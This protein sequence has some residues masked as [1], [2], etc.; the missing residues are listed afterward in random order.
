MFSQTAPAVLWESPPASVTA[1]QFWTVTLL[2]D[3]P[4]PEEVE[5][6]LPPLP[7]GLSLDRVRSEPRLLQIPPPGSGGSARRWTSLQYRFLARNPGRIDLGP[8]EV[9][10]GGTFIPGPALSLTVRNP[11]PQPPRIYWRDLPR[12]LVIGEE[13]TLTLCVEGWTRP[14]P[15]LDG[16][17][18]PPVPPMTIMETL[19]PE[20]ED[21]LLSFRLIPL[22]GPFFVFP[23]FSFP[24]E[25]RTLPVPALRIP[26][27]PAPAE[28]PEPGPTQG[29]PAPAEA[30]LP[31]TEA[32][33]ETVRIPYPPFPPDSA[34]SGGS[35]AGFRRRVQE[36]SRTLWEGGQLVEA[37]AELRRNERDHPAGFT[38][39]DYRRTLEQTLGLEDEP[40][41][42]HSPRV[43]LIPALALCLLLAALC[44]TLPAGL[45]WFRARHSQD[46]ENFEHPGSLGP[47][48]HL[49]HPGS[50]EPLIRPRC[51]GVP[52]R[53]FRGAGFFFAAA[54]FLCLLRLG[55][56]YQLSVN[57][58]GGRP[59][60]RALARE[61]AV[62]RVPDDRGT[63][64]ARLREGQGLL[65]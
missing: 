40:A 65:V 36:R 14:D 35:A 60:H 32:E 21:E 55:F 2:V 39:A 23:S 52:I 8:L 38:L 62:Y 64:I 28:K 11:S 16:L 47:L 58:H 54:A 46:P 3:H 20:G 29:A 45:A 57:Y 13:Y 27:N 18:L 4:S 63:E 59:P 12:T 31:E 26:V 61:A 24:L 34:S 10:I 44:F 37:L 43:L 33:T 53:A 22:E 19:T 1:G 30:L 42:R 6:R 50:P 15:P 17:S 9:R 49:A 56:V 51:P 41:E 7:Q 25:T 5:A 48:S